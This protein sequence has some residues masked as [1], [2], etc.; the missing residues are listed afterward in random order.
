MKS[1]FSTAKSRRTSPAF[2]YDPSI[3]AYIR[4]YSPQ[5]MA[6]VHFRLPVTVLVLGASGNTGRAVSEALL[7]SAAANNVRVRAGVRSLDK[8]PTAALPSMSVSVAALRVLPPFSSAPR[9]P[10]TQ[11]LFSSV[12]E[13]S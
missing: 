10:H 3:R 13:H 6:S 7:L 4:R 5:P 1:Q 11:S 8:V 12:N 2:L 9:H